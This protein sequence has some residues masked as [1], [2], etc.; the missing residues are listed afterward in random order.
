[1]KSAAHPSLPARAGLVRIRC[2]GVADPVATHPGATDLLVR[3][4]PTDPRGRRS[5]EVIA[6]GTAAQV[7]AHG[8]AARADAVGLDDSVLLPGLVNA[9]THLDLTHLG[10]LE[11][12]PEDGFVA[13]V[14]RIRAGRAHD[15]E[16]IAGAVRQGIE[17]SLRAGTVLVGDIAGAPGGR[18]SL[19]PLHTLA[20]SPLRGISFLEFFAIG[21][22]ERDSLERVEQT[23]RGAP[24]IDQASGV[25]LGLQPHAPNTVG[26]AGYRRAGEWARRWRL[27]LATHLAETPEEREFVLCGTGPQR[28]MLERFGLWSDAMLGEIGSGRSPVE[29]LAPVLAGSEYLLAH[30]N[31]LGEDHALAIEMLRAAGA[32]VAYCPRASAYF[33]APSHFGPHRYREM[34]RAGVNV[35]LGT[36]SVVNLPPGCERS[37]GCGMS[38]LDEARLLFRRDGADPEQ[39][40]AMMTVNGARALGWEDHSRF[41]FRAGSR[42]LGLVAVGVGGSRPG[43]SASARLLE[44]DRPATLLAVGE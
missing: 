43:V 1:M 16:A 3:L 24:A 37:E 27:R 44:S 14:E 40:L 36:D 28:A 26:L 23:L 41:S 22:R 8:E 29:H 21:S 11:H 17:L 2:A 13:W 20:L 33:G 35:C 7:N 39:L 30:V 4:G 6:I 42:P 18:P 12:R 34:L 5:L 19:A 38:V 9:H 15:A 31:D 10:P 32:S 25:R